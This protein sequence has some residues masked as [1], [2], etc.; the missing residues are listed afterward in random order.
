MYYYDTHSFRPH[1]STA[2][3][4]RCVLSESGGIWQADLRCIF[5]WPGAMTLCLFVEGGRGAV[6]PVPTY[7][8][9]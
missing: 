6:G 8:Q 5:A 4:L 1:D 9:S 2:F 7:T 3:Y